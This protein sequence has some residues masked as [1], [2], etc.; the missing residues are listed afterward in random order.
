MAIKEGSTFPEGI[1]FLYIPIDLSN[2]SAIDPLKCDI[3]IKLNMDKLI[4]KYA[5]TSTPNILLI[6][7]PGAFTPLCHEKHVLEY[8]LNLNHLKSKGVGAILVIT[9]NDP[10]V[11][12]AWGKLLTKEYVD[13]KKDSPEVVFASDTQFSSSNGLTNS[14]GGFTRNSRYATIINANS[15]KYTYFGVETER[16]VGVSGYDAVAAKL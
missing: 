1:N 7:A 12:N 16:K 11:V 9:S 10:F 3:P 2:P 14:V 15:R 5:G 13:F 4:N 6:S 8:L